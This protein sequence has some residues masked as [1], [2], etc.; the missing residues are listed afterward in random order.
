MIKISANHPLDDLFIKPFQSS[1]A[2]PLFYLFDSGLFSFLS[3]RHAVTL[4]TPRV[5]SGPQYG[6][7]EPG[8]ARSPAFSLP[9]IFESPSAHRS[10][11]LLLSHPLSPF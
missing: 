11:A 7:D 9:F 10:D 5:C 2:G 6:V 8:L 4:V 3:F 1:K